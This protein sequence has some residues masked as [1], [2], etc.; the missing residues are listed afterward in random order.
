MKMS[1]KKGFAEAKPLM[2][3]GLNVIQGQTLRT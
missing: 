1:A 2:V 3:I